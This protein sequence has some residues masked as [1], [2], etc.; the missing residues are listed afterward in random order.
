MHRNRKNAAAKVGSGPENQWRRLVFLATGDPAQVEERMAI[1]NRLADEASPSDTGIKPA[2][3]ITCATK[4]QERE[5]L[6]VIHKMVDDLGPESYIAT[7]FAGAFEDAEAN[8]ENDFGNSMKARWE[9]AERKLAAA[10]FQI[11]KLKCQK[12]RLQETVN[13]LRQEDLDRLQKKNE[14]LT[15]QMSRIKFAANS[16]YGTYRPIVDDA[17][18][19]DEEVKEAVQRMIENA[20]QPNSEMF[21]AT[22][23]DYQYAQDALARSLSMLRMLHP[24]FDTPT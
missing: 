24:A 3:E 21:R 2:Q 6:A 17:I 19:S 1:P 23:F 8:I 4:Q 18:S 22:V 7:A 14:S 5:T 12:R 9:L 20:G 13:N 15:L 16:Y 11:E 10:K